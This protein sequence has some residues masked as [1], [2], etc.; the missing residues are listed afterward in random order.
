MMHKFV[1]IINAQ[2]CNNIIMRDSV[3]FMYKKTVKINR[4]RPRYTAERVGEV[5]M[6]WGC[7]VGGRVNVLGACTCHSMH[8][9]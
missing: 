5:Y 9:V 6:G 8:A 3:T 7:E 2:L 1:L 4:W